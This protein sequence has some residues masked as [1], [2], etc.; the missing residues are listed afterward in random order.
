MRR[1][2]RGLFGGTAALAAIAASLLATAPGH[3]INVICMDDPPLTVTTPGG[4]NL[5]INNWI[6]TSTADR[7]YLHGANVTGTTQSDHHGGTLVEVYVQLPAGGSS[8][9]TVSS[10]DQRTGASG[11]ATASWG[12]VTEVLVDVPIP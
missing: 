9:V 11:H 5:T 3:A 2:S 1:V 4:T 7:T 6:K 10:V 12:G 8:A